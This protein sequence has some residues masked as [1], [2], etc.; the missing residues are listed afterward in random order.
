MDDP[1]L[2]DVNDIIDDMI[3]NCNNKNYERQL[4]RVAAISKVFEI[5]KPGDAVLI[6]GKGRDDYM[7]LGT[8]KIPYCDYDVIVNYFKKNK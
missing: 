4:D 1:R 6:I 5:A 2:E 7:A 8:E 3:S